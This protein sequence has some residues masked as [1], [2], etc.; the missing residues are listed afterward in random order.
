MENPDEVVFRLTAYPQDNNPFKFFRWVRSNIREI[1]VQSNKRPTF[2]PAH[3]YDPAV[4]GT[5][6]T[7]LVDC[8]CVVSSLS[9]Q[10]GDFDWQVLI[11]FESH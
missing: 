9:E 10:V 7:L 8:S 1:C 3:L 2:F 4:A 6:Q 11:N 5:L